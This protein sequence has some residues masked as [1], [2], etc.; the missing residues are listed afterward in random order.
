MFMLEKKWGYFA[1]MKANLPIYA[2][3]K[4]QFYS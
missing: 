2:T 3:E 4:E 1:S